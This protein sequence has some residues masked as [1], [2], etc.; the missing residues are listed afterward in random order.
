VPYPPADARNRT[1]L[2]QTTLGDHTIERARE[3]DEQIL[4]DGEPW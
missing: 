1:H 3:E 4:C 2:P